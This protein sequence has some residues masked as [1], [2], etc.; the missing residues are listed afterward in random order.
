MTGLTASL[1]Q[2]LVNIKYEQVPAGA[3]PLIRNAFTDTVAVIMVGITEP[4]VDIVR[5]TMVVAGSRRDAR[6]PPSSIYFSAP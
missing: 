6:A 3:L 1:G 2:F 5:R 4:I